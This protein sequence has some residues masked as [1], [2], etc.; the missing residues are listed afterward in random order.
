MKSRQDKDLRGGGHPNKRLLRGFSAI[1]ELKSLI[2]RGKGEIFSRL[3]RNVASTKNAY[4]PEITSAKRLMPNGFSLGDMLIAL[5]V[6]GALAVILIPIYKTANPD[7]LES[8]H[9][10]ATF[11]VERITNELS[12]DEYLYPISSNGEY[13]GLSNTEQ[14]ELNG[15]IHGGST[16][17]CSLFASRLNLM[18]GSE[19]RCAQ[20]EKSATSIEG[21]DWYLPIS[22]FKNGPETLIV[23]VNSNE[24]PNCIYDEDTCPR[25]DRFEYLIQPGEKIPVKEVQ[26]YEATGAPPAIETVED[27][28]KTPEQAPRPGKDAHSINCSAANATVYGAGGG[29]I[30]GNY[31]LVAVPKRGYKCNWFTKQITVDGSDVNCDL[32]CEY[33]LDRPLADGDPVI[34]DPEPEP[35]GDDDDEDNTYCINVEVTGD[36]SECTLSGDGCGKEPGKHVVTLTPNDQTKYT[37]SWQSNTTPHSQTVEIVD[38]DVS[39]I[40]DCRPVEHEECYS[41]SVEGAEN[42]PVTLPPGNCPNEGETDKYINGTYN[43]TVKPNEGYQYNNR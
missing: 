20:N 24:L 4:K 37:T 14:V 13:K 34:P 39:I 19:V 2:T 17:F 30:D 5:G 10:K 12:S 28:G 40:V 43:V 38:K 7:K 1:K 25:P 23:D 36:A 26:Y 18:P 41:I 15:S 42:C 32:Q 3:T 21:I 27:T 35:E 22:E 31:M 8:M 16:K 11:I 6:I 33:G 9:K 29:K